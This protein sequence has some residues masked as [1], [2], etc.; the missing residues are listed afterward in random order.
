[1]SAP[2]GGRVH[3]LLWNLKPDFKKA[4]ECI[5]NYAIHRY[6]FVRR[7]RKGI[8]EIFIVVRTSK[9]CFR[10]MYANL[11]TRSIEYFSCQKSS[12]VALRMWLIYQRTKTPFIGESKYYS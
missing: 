9:R 5:Y 10:V 7:D 1:M 6:T 3:W 4:Y 8:N 12:H 11:E 2:C